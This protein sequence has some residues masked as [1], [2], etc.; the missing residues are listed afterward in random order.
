MSNEELSI[1]YELAERQRAQL[2]SDGKASLEASI[3][4]TESWLDK[5]TVTQWGTQPGAHYFRLVYRDFL[6]TFIAHL[7]G[8]IAQIDEFTTRLH[9]ALRE[10]QNNEEELQQVVHRIVAEIDEK[11]QKNLFVPVNKPINP[12]GHPSSPYLR[13][14]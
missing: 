3:A 6:E 8:N 9:Q 10:F 2:A 4:A 14:E 1:D 5:Q 11:S 7:K 12:Q 13:M